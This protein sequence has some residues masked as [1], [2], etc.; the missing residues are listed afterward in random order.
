MIIG[1]FFDYSLI[2][3]AA[4]VGLVATARIGLAPRDPSAGIAVVFAPWTS[5]GDALAR[6]MQPGGRLVRTGQWPFIVIVM[7]D[8]PDYATRVLADGALLV[9]D[10]RKL[11]A[12]FTLFSNAKTTS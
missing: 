8:A 10:P 2:A 4:I 9:V 11:E 6:A 5:P 7:P 12:C 1:R 3:C